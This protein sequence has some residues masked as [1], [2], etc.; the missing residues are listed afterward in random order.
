MLDKFEW[1]SI[2]KI[3]VAKQYHVSRWLIEE[4]IKVLQTRSLTIDEVLKLELRV[5]MKTICLLL[6]VK[7]R[8]WCSASQ[9][10]GNQ[11]ARSIPDYLKRLYDFRRD[12]REVFE[13]EL[14]QDEEYQS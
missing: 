14:K 9:T 6:A 11:Y 8:S 10:L 1:D 3:V 5:G 2:D 7:E 13:E 12:V 4:Y